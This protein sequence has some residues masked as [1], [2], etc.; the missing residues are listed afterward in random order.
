M[1]TADHPPVLKSKGGHLTVDNVRL[2]HRLC[3]RIH[4]SIE[5]GRPHA[6]DLA[7]VKSARAAAMS[8]T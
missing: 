1:P 8:K 2:A 4:Y 7:R 3:N 6:K 5:T